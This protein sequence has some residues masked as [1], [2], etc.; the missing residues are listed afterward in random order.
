[1]SSSER[2][3][4]SNNSPST[5]PLTENARLLVGHLSEKAPQITKAAT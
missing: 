4:T 3:G 2:R 5:N 1:M